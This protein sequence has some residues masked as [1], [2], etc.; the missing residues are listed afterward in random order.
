MFSSSILQMMKKIWEKK[1][2]KVKQKSKPVPALE[3]P[4]VCCSRSL[5]QLPR[6]SDNYLQHSGWIKFQF[7]VEVETFAVSKAVVWLWYSGLIF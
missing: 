6:T 1:L 3:Q 5:G 2:S 7:I 4:R